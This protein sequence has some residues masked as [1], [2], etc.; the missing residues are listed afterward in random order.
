MGHFFKEILPLYYHAAFSKYPVLCLQMLRK[1]DFFTLGCL[2]RTSVSSWS[3][4]NLLRW[5]ASY[6]WLCLSWWS[7]VGEGRWATAKANF[8][9]GYD[10]TDFYISPYL[11]CF[12]GHFCCTYR[13]NFFYTYLNLHFAIF[14]FRHP[15]WFSETVRRKPRASS[16][17]S[18]HTQLTKRLTMIIIVIIKDPLFWKSPFSLSYS[19]N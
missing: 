12:Y 13:Y 9:C 1:K 7:S 16:F 18:N 5:A 14:C 19:N 6:L 2:H 10:Y 17:V 8:P 11:G 3:F 4:G 15:F